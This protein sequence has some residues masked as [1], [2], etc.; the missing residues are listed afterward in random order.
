MPKKI[1]YTGAKFYNERQIDE[2]LEVVKNDILEGIILFGVFYGM[3]RAEI[4][5]LKWSAI[6]FENKTFTIQHTVVQ[7]C[8]K[9]YHKDSTKNKSSYRTLPMPGIIIDMLKRIKR[10]QA[11]NKLLQPNDYVD[12]GYIFTRA[13]G[14]LIM[15]NYVTKHF[16]DI[17]IKNKLPI[18][19][20]HDL[21]H[22]AASYLLYL[23]FSMKEIQM[24][25]GHGDIGTTMNI[26]GHLDIEAKRNI[27][28]TLN[29]KF[30]KFGT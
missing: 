7:N 12:D 2:L 5:G 16:K 23:G 29:E 14:R 13:D 27:A 26:Y 9:I 30:K 19:R 11:Q 15:P 20:L 1:K 21:R 6:S 4:M 25:L 3:R 28:D 8:N 22:S 17:L 18:I 24:W 10:N